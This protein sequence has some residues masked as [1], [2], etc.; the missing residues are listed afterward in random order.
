MPGASGVALLRLAL[1]SFANRGASADL[2]A[3]D[4][5]GEPLA[6][7][8]VLGGPAAISNH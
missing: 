4:G 1:F 6:D 5:S 8:G 2:G 7:G 3:M